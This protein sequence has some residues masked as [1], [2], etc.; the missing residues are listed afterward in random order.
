M[1]IPFDEVEATG[2]EIH[3]FSIHYN[4]QEKLGM[5]SQPWN[6]ISMQEDF[7]NS[8]ETGDL[9]QGPGDG[10]SQ[11]LLYGPQFDA[12]GNPITDP[13]FEKFD[14]SDPT[15][16]R[17]PDGAPL[18]LTPN[19]N[20]LEPRCLRQ[21]GARL[22]KW[23]LD[24]NAGRYLSADF[25]IFRY[26]DILLLKAEAIV[27]GGGSGDAATYVNMVRERAGLDALGAVTLDDIYW[28]RG[29]EF[30]AE[31]HRRR[32]MIRFGTYNNPR[33]EADGS[34]PCKTLFPVPMEQIDVNANLVQNPCY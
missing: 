9:R 4:L 29:H 5:E 17:D 1:G 33:W 18:N 27:R 23:E 24:E 25:P 34:E 10:S 2:L 14:P 13:S 31:G 12:D 21:A 16:P 6:G 20:E 28:E 11:G 32:D 15:G 3:L 8:F 30:Y 7:F 19:I 26:A 22:F